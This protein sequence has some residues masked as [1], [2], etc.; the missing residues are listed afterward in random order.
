MPA[1]ADCPQLLAHS[2]FAREIDVKKM[3]QQYRTI[4]IAGALTE[5]FLREVLSDNNMTGFNIVVSDFSRIF[6][7]EATFYKFIRRGGSIQVRQ[8]AN[9]IALCSNPTSPDGYNFAP[10]VL[11][12]ALTEELN[13]PVYDIMQAKKISLL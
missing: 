7:S 6:A 3:L 10:D 5:N 13:L 8:R 1:T 4:Y 9:L 11:Q 2:L 12:N